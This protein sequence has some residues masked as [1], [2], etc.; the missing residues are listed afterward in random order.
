MA[1]NVL[2]VDD[3]RTTRG[4]IKKTLAIAQLPIGEVFEAENGDQALELLGRKDVGVILTD[5]NMPGTDGE[6]LLRLVREDGVLQDTPVIVI[7][8]EGSAPRIGEL[9]SLGMNAYLRKPFTPE[10]LREVMLQILGD[11]LSE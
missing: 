4:V 6:S 7:S 1:V 3:S 8:T 2:I 10:Q 11:Q 9:N 5:L